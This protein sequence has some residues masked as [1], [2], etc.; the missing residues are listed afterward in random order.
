MERLHGWTVSNCR[1]DKW[2]WRGSGLADFEGLAQHDGHAPETRRALGTAA[3]SGRP[4][5]A[6]STRSAQRQAAAGQA[7]KAGNNTAVPAADRSARRRRAATGESG[8]DGRKQAAGRFRNY[9]KP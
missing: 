1:A 2:I 5:D 7:G 6:R 9:G 4:H 8:I 3:R